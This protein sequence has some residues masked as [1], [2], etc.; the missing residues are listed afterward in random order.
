MKSNIIGNKVK[1]ANMVD[2]LLLQANQPTTDQ[3]FIRNRIEDTA[4]KFLRSVNSTVQLVFHLTTLD[5][6][7][8]VKRF[9]PSKRY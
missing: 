8:S 9:A 4:K 1:H 3:V 5:S 6:G 7:I 2:L